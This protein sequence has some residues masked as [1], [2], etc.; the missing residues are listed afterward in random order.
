[1]K[2]SIRHK[3][4][5]LLL[6]AP[7]ATLCAQQLDARGDPEPRAFYEQLQ[8]TRSAEQVE[9][10]LDTA[11]PQ[12]ARLA[13]IRLVDVDRAAALPILRSLWDG[14]ALPHTMKHTGTYQHPIAR[15]ALAEQLMSLSPTPAYKDYIKR[16]VGH[17]SWIVRSLA[18]EALSVVDDAESIDLL[19]QLAR[20]GNPLIA[21]SAIASLSQLARSGDYA[22][23]AN[24]ALQELRNGARM[25]Q[26][27]V[28]NN[29]TEAREYSPLPESA[30]DRSLDEKVQQSLE[31]QQYQA[32]IDLLLPGA[33]N[34]NARAQHLVGELYL[35]MSPP[36]YD[37]AREW[38]QRAVKQDYAPAKTGLANLYLSGR[39]VEQ[40]EQ[41][42]VRLLQE[43]EQQGEQSAHLLLEKAREQ[44]WW[45]L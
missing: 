35:A 28:R 43:A 20:S 8:R 42:A 22:I 17:A 18:A 25:E 27:K 33:E 13:I 23:E 21:E 39:G 19:M 36:D 3:W 16:A 12:N 31:K 34:G 6:I 32:A 38:F 14:R 44:G 11:D 24:Q 40:D 5:V 4:A 7:S 45:G 30:A 15:L 1:M 29:I 26:G 41:E 10:L 2:R 9:S 37:R